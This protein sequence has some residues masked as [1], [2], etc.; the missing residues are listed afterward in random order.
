MSSR[1]W[2][3]LQRKAE[4][5]GRAGA[6]F[7]SSAGGLL[8]RRWHRKA[9]RCECF[10]QRYLLTLWCAC[11]HNGMFQDVVLTLCCGAPYP[12]QFY[13]DGVLQS[14]RV[15][16]EHG[17]VYVMLNHSQ[18]TA[19]ESGRRL[20]MVQ[21][22]RHNKGGAAAKCSTWG[23]QRVVLVLRCRAATSGAWQLIWRVQANGPA[24]TRYQ[25]F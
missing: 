18:A 14:K 17:D 7:G 24:R 8:W 3:L 21:H 16:T 5:V 10:L 13:R 25:L 4:R 2:V 9:H 15:I 22:G 19:V 23:D 12:L 1:S 20:G 11:Q 6:S